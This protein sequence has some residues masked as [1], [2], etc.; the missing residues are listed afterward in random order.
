MKRLHFRFFC[1]QNEA[2]RI[3]GKYRERGKKIG[4][5][6]FWPH[7]FWMSCVLSYSASSQP[8]K[9]ESADVLERSEARLREFARIHSGGSV[10]YVRVCPYHCACTDGAHREMGFPPSRSAR[11][12][13]THGAPGKGRAPLFISRRGQTFRGLNL[14]P[15]HIISLVGK[16][17]V[18]VKDDAN[19]PFA[20]LRRPIIYVYFLLF[21]VSSNRAGVEILSF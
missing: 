15:P 6:G 4:V 9:K 8:R 7:C 10:E 20:P 11:S 21:D 2:K 14:M 12:W 18:N 19:T 13:S 17:A 1:V 3:C 5:S 16:G